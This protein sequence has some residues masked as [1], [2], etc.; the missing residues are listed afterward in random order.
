MRK[1]LE[2]C[3]FH[4]PKIPRNELGEP[5]DPSLISVT[6]KKQPAAW[7]LIEEQ[8]N[9][10]YGLNPKKV[11]KNSNSELIDLREEKKKE[12]KKNRLL[13]IS[14][15]LGRNRDLPAW[16]ERGKEKSVFG[17]SEK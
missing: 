12:K 9:S 3:P 2:R 14:K 17:N 1:D 6:N 13:T 11:R 4:G 8:I 16:E 5:I 10:Q 7:E 15:R